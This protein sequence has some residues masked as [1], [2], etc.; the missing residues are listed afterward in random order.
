MGPA[1]WATIALTVSTAALPVAHAAC[2]DSVPVSRA[3]ESQGPDG[4]PPFNERVRLAD[5][6]HGE[7]ARETDPEASGALAVRWVRAVRAALAAIPMDA[8]TQPPYRDFLERHGSEVVYSEPAGEWLLRDDVIWSLQDR[9]RATSSAE[10]IAWEAADNTLPGECEGYP[11]CD[12]AQLDLLYGEYLRREPAG[13]HAD[14]A[15]RRIDA[16]VREIQRLLDGRGGD[17]FFNPVTDCV[18]LTRKAK[19]LL[20][21]L[22][23][24]QGDTSGTRAA[25]SALAARCPTR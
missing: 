12:L 22:S 10:A 16:S 2:P 5:R 1:L 17:E 9:Y 21:A 14:E 4:S 19:A 13:A 18:D 11:P 6:V 20:D 24:A 25:L 8:R 23:R 15:T 3:L 7:M